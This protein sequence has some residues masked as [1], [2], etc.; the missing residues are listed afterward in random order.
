MHWFRGRRESQKKHF[1]FSGDA[2]LSLFHANKTFLWNPCSRFS[3]NSFECLEIW[4]SILEPTNSIHD[5]QKHWGLSFKLR[6]STYNTL[7]STSTEFFPTKYLLA[8][9]FFYQTVNNLNCSITYFIY[10]FFYFSSLPQS[11]RHQHLVLLNIW[12]INSSNLKG[13]AAYLAVNDFSWKKTSPTNPHNT[14][15]ECSWVL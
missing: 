1:A 2:L 3:K 9:F 11:G 14:W 15:F 8:N 13:W 10:F 12:Q 4:N 7:I 5:S 6:L